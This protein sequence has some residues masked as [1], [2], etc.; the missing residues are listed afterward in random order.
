MTFCLQ[1]SAKFGTFK[2]I[3]FFWI[4]FY[5]HFPSSYH[6]CKPVSFH[7]SRSFDRNFL[8]I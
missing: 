6:A 2:K 5:I 3:F 7:Y 8:I 1:G 4:N